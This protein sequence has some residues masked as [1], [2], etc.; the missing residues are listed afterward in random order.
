M[1]QAVSLAWRERTIGPR[2][3]AIKLLT[4][5]TLVATFNLLTLWVR[6]CEKNNNETNVNA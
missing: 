6:V 3:F 4:I 2:E 5:R 1:F